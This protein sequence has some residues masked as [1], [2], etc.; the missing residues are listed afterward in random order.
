MAVMDAKSDAFFKAINDASKAHNEA[1]INET[2]LFKQTEIEKAKEEAQK[3][4]EEYILHATSRIAIENGVEA[5]RL[6]LELKKQVIKAR[7]DIEKSVFAGVR[8]RI[9]KFTK[10]E[11]YGKMLIESANQMLQQCDGYEIVIYIRSC[12]KKYENQIKALS[13]KIKTEIDN[14]IELGGIY[15]ICSEKSLK[16]NDCLDAK[17][18]AQKAWF[19]ENSGL[20]INH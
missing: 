15:C 14:S 9:I 4:Y 10:T 1:I 6:S 19:H 16:L 20:H 12:D 17:L 3:K 2:Q 13:D 7:E 8:E 18:E 11:E 5:E